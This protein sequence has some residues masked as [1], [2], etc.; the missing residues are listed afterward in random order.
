MKI[1]LALALTLLCAAAVA[2]SAQTKA[3]GI[4]GKWNMT[5]TGPD[6]QPMQVAA[7]F[8]TAGK[9]L[10]G[11]LT[12]PQGEVALEGEFDAGKIAFGITV[13]GD[14]GAPM[15]IGFAGKMAED[16]TMSGMATG[17]FGEIPWK[18]ERAK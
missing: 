1:R 14:G 17:P 16:G 8:K 13:P 2:V 11:T 12:G 9:K 6:G 5:V 7:V 4:D 3:A 18:A 10:S 15:T